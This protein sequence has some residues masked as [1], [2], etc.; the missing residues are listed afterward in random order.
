MDNILR[1]TKKITGINNEI[2]D[3]KLYL[4]TLVSGS[5][6]GACCHTVMATEHFNRTENC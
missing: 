3:D 2:I 5:W 6:Y 1:Y 4:A